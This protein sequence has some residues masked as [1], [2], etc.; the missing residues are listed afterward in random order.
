[1][2]ASIPAAYGLKGHARP[3]GTVHPSPDE[4]RSTATAIPAQADGTGSKTLVLLLKGG[5]YLETPRNT[6][7]LARCRC[8]LNYSML[9]MWKAASGGAIHPPTEDRGMNGPF[10]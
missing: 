1:M 6:L 3:Y 5:I 2:T 10:L 7:L 4:Q 8:P 9:G